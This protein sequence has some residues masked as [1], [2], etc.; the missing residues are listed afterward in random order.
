MTL[1]VCIDDRGGMTFNSRR[2]SKDEKVIE[3]VLIHTN[4]N[5]LYVTDFSEDLFEASS[6]CVISVPSPLDT[7]KN[8]VFVFIENLPILPHVHKI[9][10]LVIYHWNRAYPYDTVLDIDPKK[11]GFKLTRVTEFEGKSHK[12]ITKEVYER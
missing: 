2:Q 4:G 12:K 11:Q 7:S 10:S 9:K 1:F 6:S 3:D 5:P 8:G